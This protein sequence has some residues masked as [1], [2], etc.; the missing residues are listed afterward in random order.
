MQKTNL[1]SEDFTYCKCQCQEWRGEEEHIS[2]CNNCT[3]GSVGAF[4]TARAASAHV[5]QTAR[6]LSL[7]ELRSGGCDTNAQPPCCTSAPR[8]TRL[9]T[10]KQSLWQHTYPTRATTR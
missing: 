9:A 6:R 5:A 7:A 10:S 3:A 1:T 4:Y 2:M 8:V